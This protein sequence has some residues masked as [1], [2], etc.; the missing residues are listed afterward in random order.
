MPI[1]EKTEE[2]YFDN[3]FPVADLID[4]FEST[5]TFAIFQLFK[6]ALFTMFFVFRLFS[7]ISEQWEAIF[8]TCD[9]S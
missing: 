5:N 9:G 4:G 3:D 2:T 1:I 6:T 7:I 8:I